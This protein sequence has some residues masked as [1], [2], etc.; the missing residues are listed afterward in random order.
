MDVLA[1]VG[2]RRGHVAYSEKHNRGAW[3]E[4]AEV[5]MTRRRAA[6]RM[7]RA[8]TISPKPPAGFGLPVCPHEEKMRRCAPVRTLYEEIGDRRL[9][10]FFPSSRQIFSFL[11]LPIPSPVVG[12]CHWHTG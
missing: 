7:Q 4:D 3:V 8:K 6:R 9:V 11:P 2:D 10:Q 1:G 5:A 12:T